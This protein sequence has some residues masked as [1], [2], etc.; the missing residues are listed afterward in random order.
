MGKSLVDFEDEAAFCVD[1][2]AFARRSEA[3]SCI[4]AGA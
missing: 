1:A 4:S 2:V 3:E